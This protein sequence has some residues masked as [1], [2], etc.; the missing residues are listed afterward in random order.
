[1][2][3]IS[4][5]FSQRIVCSSSG[6]DRVA[7][8]FLEE[9][10]VFSQVV[11]YLRAIAIMTGALL[12]NRSTRQIAPKNFELFVQLVVKSQCLSLTAEL[13]TK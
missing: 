10:S 8:R 12:L 9:T 4:N 3:V 6:H 5:L 1:M 11:A 2:S 7:C 13:L